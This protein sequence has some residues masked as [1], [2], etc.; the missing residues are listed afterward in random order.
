MP[1]PPVDAPAAPEGPILFFD[2]ACG[3]CNGWVDRFLRAD[4]RGVLRFAT[5]Q[6]ETAR[7]LLPPLPEDPSAW[8]LVLLDRGRTR[9]ESDA[10]LE[11]CRLVGG[12]YALLALA[13][14]VPRFLRR[15]LYRGVARRRY[16]WFGR[17]ESCRVPTE[18]ERGRFL[19]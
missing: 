18:A 17:R 5:L 12:R 3:L 14:F 16:R 2:G 9:A 13:R 11:A 6:G 19:P 15:P 10:A 8:S 4:R 1:A 7:R